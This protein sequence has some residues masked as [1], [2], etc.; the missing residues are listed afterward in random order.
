MHRIALSISAFLL[1]TGTATV[2]SAQQRDRA[3]EAADPDCGYAC[4]FA[5][6][7]E[8]APS[9]DGSAPVLGRAPERTATP[10]QTPPSAIIPASLQTPNITNGPDNGR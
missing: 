5:L 2:G 6:S 3:P 7:S 10:M 4:V 9:I 1:I 8:P